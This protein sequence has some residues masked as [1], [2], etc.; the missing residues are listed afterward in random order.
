MTT[1]CASVI[2]LNSGAHLNSE[3]TDTHFCL[4]NTGWCPGWGRKGLLSSSGRGRMPMTPFLCLLLYPGW[5]SPLYPLWF[6]PGMGFPHSDVS[7]TLS[8]GSNQDRTNI[9]MTSHSEWLCL[10]QLRDHSYQV[11]FT[12]SLRERARTDRKTSSLSVSLHSVMQAS[13]ERKDVHG[14]P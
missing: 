10:L 4:W 6:H 7:S 5:Y 3:E 8:I 13:Q 11:G 1:S 9:G 2:I 14:L 12:G